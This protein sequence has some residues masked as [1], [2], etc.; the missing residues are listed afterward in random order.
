MKKFKPVAKQYWETSEC[1]PKE[2]CSV[3]RISYR[4]SCRWINQWSTHNARS[5]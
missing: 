2:M 1:K 3:F 4:T 5:N